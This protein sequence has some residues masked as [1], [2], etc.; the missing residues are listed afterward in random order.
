MITHR[1]ILRDLLDPLEVIIMKTPQSEID[2]FLSE[3]KALEGLEY[4]TRIVQ[5][6]ALAH[7]VVQRIVEYE[8]PAMLEQMPAWI[9]SLV[10][11][12]RDSYRRVGY[13][14]VYS[15]VGSPPTDHSELMRK[16]SELLPTSV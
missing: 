15:S 11:Q 9:Q 2:Q 14:R 4:D 1:R 12:M 10:L 5:G 8:D 16:L 3:S 6:M 7:G 13:Y